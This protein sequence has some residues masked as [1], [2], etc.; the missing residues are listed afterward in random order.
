VTTLTRL[1]YPEW[2]EAEMSTT[3]RTFIKDAVAL[4]S[5]IASQSA[6]RTAGAQTNGYRRIAVEEI[7]CPPEVIEASKRAI[8]ANPNLEPNFRELISE[9]TPFSANVVQRMQD[10]GEER[11]RVMDEGGIAK[12]VLSN[13]AP[14][15]QIF[16]AQ[17]G[18][19]LAALS[20]DRMADAVRDNPDR[21]AALATI[22]PQDPA[23]AALEVERAIS[24]LGLNGVLINSHTH[25]EYLDDTKFWPIL[26]ACVANNAAIYL[27]PRVPSAQMFGPF[28]SYNMHAAKWG[29]AMEVSTHVVRLIASGV[30]DEFPDLRLVLGH[31]G[32][33]L[34]FWLHRLDTMSRG[35]VGNTIDKPPSAYVRENMVITT[36]GMGWDP[37]LLLSHSV[38]GA[39]NIL[40]AVDYPFGDYSRDSAWMDS[41]PLP[42]ADKVKIY[43]TN[44][45]RIF[46]LA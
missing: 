6:T 28:S 10:V 26:E 8:N 7:F 20:N 44:A 32:E 12:A 4:S 36:S 37:I 42:E 22:A 13:W 34:P 45:E 15:V 41:A 27:H 5:L 31:M 17:E 14:G 18:T 24:T 25:N 16:E 19:E 23:S 2:I 3:R 40:F 9:A 38:L 46:H 35:E 30:L 1:S 29:F 21:F 33:G 11:L 43:S 39:D